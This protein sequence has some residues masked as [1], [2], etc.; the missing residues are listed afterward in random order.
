V[1]PSSSLFNANTIMITIVVVVVVI[2]QQTHQQLGRRVLLDA[3]PVAA[4][5]HTTSI[6]A[7]HS[8]RVVDHGDRAAYTGFNV[9]KHTFV[10][11]T[12]THNP[13]QQLISSQ[14]ISQSVNQ[15]KTVVHI[16]GSVDLF[17]FLLF[18]FDFACAGRL[19]KP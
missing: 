15:T 5:H 13:A 9:L 19:R 11:Q 18:A 17:A 1:V 10:T 7:A 16:Y 14:S 6:P 3:L 4:Q 12:H 2:L 8:L